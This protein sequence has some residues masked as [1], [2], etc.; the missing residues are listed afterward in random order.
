MAI[1]A[2]ILINILIKVAGQLVELNPIHIPHIHV[3]KKASD[4]D[5]DELE[6]NNNENIG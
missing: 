3:K 6:E 2:Y 4:D 1:C 5:N